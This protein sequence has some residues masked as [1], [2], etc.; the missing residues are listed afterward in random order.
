MMMA[1]SPP[2]DDPEQAPRSSSPNTILT[3][4][5]AG[6][7]PKW[8]ALSVLSLIAWLATL[9]GVQ[10]HQMDTAEKWALATT[11]LSVVFAVLGVLCYLFA[12]GMF[13]GELPEVVLVSDICYRYYCSIVSQEFCFRC[14][15]LYTGTRSF[16]SL[17]FPTTAIVIW[18]DSISGG[19]RHSY[20]GN[21]TSYYYEPRQW[22]CCRIYRLF[23]CQFIFLFLVFIFCGH[24]D[25][26]RIG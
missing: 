12:R 24:L 9:G 11:T 14:I 1:N 6:R 3:Q 16:L 7:F 8:I 25:C 13:M 19:C 26:G 18:H 15:I 20:L 22:Y 21:W 23:E 17:Y 5:N 2:I 4:Y 10:R